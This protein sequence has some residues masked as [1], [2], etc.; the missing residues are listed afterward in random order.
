NESAARLAEGSGIAAPSAGRG[1]GARLRRLGSESL[2]YGLSSSVGRV[3]SYLL[4]PYYAYA[5]TPAENG[6][7]SVVYTYIPLVSLVFLLGLEVAYMRGAAATRDAPLPV[8]QRTFSMSF[9]TI[10]LVGAAGVVLGWIAAPWLAAAMKLPEYSI[11]Y[12]LAIVYTDALLTVPYAHLRMANQAKRYAALKLLFAGASIALNVILIGALDWDV[13][14]I[15]FSNLVA[16]L[17]VL[18]L[19][20]PIILRLFRPALLRGAEWGPLWRY[21]LPLIPAALAV[22]IVENGDRIVLNSLSDA[23]ARAVYGMDTKDVVGIYSFNYKLGVAMLLVVQ[24]FRMAWTPFSLTQAKQPGAP[25]LFS[26]VLTGLMIV[27]SGVLLAVSIF[28]PVLVHVPAVYRFPQTPAY[29]LGLSIVPVIL[30]GYAFSGVYAVVTAGLYVER[31]TSVLPWISGAG[32]LVNLAICFVAARRGGMV[33]V[34]WAT[35]ASYAIMAGL[36]AWQANRV[37]PVPFEWGRLA[38]LAAIG[39]AIFAADHWLLPRLVHAGSTAEAGIKLLLL[40]AF[41][42]L[43]LLTR[44]FR[45]GEWAVLRRLVPGS[46]RG[47]EAQR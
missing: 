30:L 1:F 9:G 6:V 7:Q 40:L 39:T 25:Q 41:P 27:C 18:A 34:A 29:W 46:H 45:A 24:M 16:N 33:A 37:Y 17:A 22:A 10:A 35:P 31:R 23:S 12:I 47:T 32:A 4:T 13:S 14:A 11:R 2:V 36:G 38:H 21:A 15:F 20:L 28:L 26:R 8:R 42:A 43:L 19:M 44:F 3:L 5:F